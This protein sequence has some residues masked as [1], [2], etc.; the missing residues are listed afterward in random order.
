MVKIRQA[1]ILLL[2]M[3]MMPIGAQT[4]SLVWED[5]FDGQTL[6]SSIWSIEEK[7]GIWNTGQNAEFQHY[8]RE[9][10]QVGDDGNGNNC[11]IL[12]AKEEDYKGFSY[13]SGKVFT[14]GKFAFR[15]GKMEAAIRVPDLANGLWPAFWTLGYVPLGWPDNGE[16]DI[17]EMGHSGAIADDTVNSFVGAHLF[18]GPY[19]NGYPNYGTDYTAGEDLSQGYF[20]HTA[21]WTETSIKVYFNNAS[22]PYFT[23]TITGNDFEE[24]RDYQHYILFNL[25]VGG[26]LPGISNKAD[27]SAPMPASMYVDWVRLYQEVDET[28]MNDSTLALFGTVGL[29]EE[30]DANGFYMNHAFDLLDESSGLSDRLEADPYAGDQA[31]SYEVQSGQDFEFSL[32]SVLPRNMIN[33]LEGSIQFYLK[34]DLNSDFEIGVADSSGAKHFVNL[35]GYPAIDLP[36]DGSWNLVYVPLADLLQGVDV[37]SLTDLLLIR[38]TSEAVGYFSVDEVIYSELVPA[39][40]FYGIYVDDD[41]YS[42]K[43]EI[44]NVTGHLYNW[45]NTVKFTT[46]FPPFEGDNVLSFKSSGAQS[47]YGFGIFSDQAINLQNFKDGYL[48]ISMITEASGD[49]YIGMDADDDS[50]ANIDFKGSSGPYGFERDGTWQHLSIPMS[51]LLAKGL[52]LSQVKHVLKTGG[53]SI[54]DI[55]FDRIFLSAEQ[56]EAPVGIHRTRVETW[57]ITAYSDGT[58]HLRLRGL[59]PGAG[60]SIFTSDGR[61][62][63]GF[64]AHSTEQVISIASYPPGIYIISSVH[65]GSYASV[66]FVR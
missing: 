46:V 49:F 12:T 20:I 58:D 55:A 27:I 3:A 11:L 53:A 10:V 51:D 44:N 31:L 16:I 33:Y 63:D 4:W 17:M 41:S 65:E 37:E 22:S 23:M 28:D 5:Q 6:D 35:S 62:V 42:P 25:A 66:K 39:S 50:G 54:G 38:G 61:W 40:D 34:T 57:K 15:R 47:W 9:N 29:Y 14:K 13:T 21:V 24:F 60:I 32:R 26:S 1:I 52:N 19:N 56:Q 18:W 2:F 43:F 59:K 36:R 30:N 48:N 45:E 7:K 64:Q 8:R